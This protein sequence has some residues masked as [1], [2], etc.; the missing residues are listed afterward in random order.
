MLLLLSLASL[1][2]I[3]GRL[4]LPAILPRIIDTFDIT[5]AEAG[6]ALTVLVASIAVSQYIGGRLSDQLTRKTVLAASLVLFIAGFAVLALASSYSLVLLGAAIAGL[7][8]G[9]YLPSVFAQLSD[10]F[11]DRRG[12]A[13][14]INNAS[15]S[16]GSA[17][18]P[19]IAIAAVGVGQW[20]LAFVPVVLALGIALILL[21]RWSIEGYVVSP[22]HL[23]LRA[24]TARLVASHPIRRSLVAF[25]LVGFVW[26]SGLNFVPTYLQLERGFSEP[27]AGAAFAGLF[28][29]GMLAT[30][31]AG[32]LGDRFGYPAVAAAG[33][34]IGL[35]G[36][37]L[38]V[39]FTGGLIVVLGVLLFGG[40]ISSFWPVMNAYVMDRFPSGSLAGDFGALN[41]VNL[42][43][44]SLGPV[45]VG[46]L[47]ER[48]SYAVA[49]SSLAI[50][51]A[52]CIGLLA[53]LVRTG[54]G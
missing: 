29:A 45:Y 7:G 30:P 32:N 43:V 13:F 20:R 36:L 11:V 50:P 54:H 46:L 38:F 37:G 39:T 4:I 44:G 12:Q 15:Y 19:G 27:V 53:W 22:V 1:S 6:F 23:D 5:P 2:S 3:A 40:G 33:L 17:L 47:A 18:A 49:F 16:L 25:A 34:T 41:T 9:L 31:L 28:L 51:F 26:Q 52:A 48:A 10:L 21:H 8:N 35:L 42:A 14:G 24:T